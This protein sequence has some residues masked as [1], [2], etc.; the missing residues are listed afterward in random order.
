MTR[1]AGISLLSSWTRRRASQ[2]VV[3]SASSIWVAVPSDI[4]WRRA[5]LV[6]L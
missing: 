3:P 6:L 1:C 5:T 2:T 4:E